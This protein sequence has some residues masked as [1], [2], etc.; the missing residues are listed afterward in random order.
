M[1]MRY[2]EIR[3]L[4]DGIFLI[5]GRVEADLDNELCNIYS[6]CKEFDFKHIHLDD[7]ECSITELTGANALDRWFKPV[8]KPE[9]NVVA[10][11]HVMM[12]VMGQQKCLSVLLNF[13]RHSKSAVIITCNDYPFSG[14]GKCIGMLK[15]YVRHQRTLSVSD[16]DTKNSFCHDMS[17][18]TLELLTLMSI[19]LMDEDGA[20]YDAT[21]D[22]MLQI[23]LTQT[24][25]QTLGLQNYKSP[26]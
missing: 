19:S 20:N 15:A 13:I 9:I 17:L 25:M 1:K 10:N 18:G 5:I 26:D 12:S 16:A 14:G 8:S 11:L 2:S 23:C 21:D 6:E 22:F 24:R 7:L 3:K 4:R